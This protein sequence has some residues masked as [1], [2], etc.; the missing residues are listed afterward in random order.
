MTKEQ[1][2]KEQVRGF[3]ARFFKNYALQD[4]DHIFS[5]G[6]INSLFAMELV[7]FVEKT[8]GI[9]VENDD[10]DMKNFQ[11]V[12]AIASFVEQKLS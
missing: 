6:F 11:S 3:L 7:L 4:D 12:S 9:T 2:Y 8:F 10:L 1:Y 5:L